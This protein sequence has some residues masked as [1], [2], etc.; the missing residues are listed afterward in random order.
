MRAACKLQLL[1]QDKNTQKQKQKHTREHNHAT[2]RTINPTRKPDSTN[3]V[4]D[5]TDAGAQLPALASTSALVTTR[6]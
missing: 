5:L 4:Q 3:K 2:N 6:Q 1:V